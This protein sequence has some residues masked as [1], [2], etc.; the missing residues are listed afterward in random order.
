MI[1]SSVLGLN[2]GPLE[3][4]TDRQ[5][6]GLTSELQSL[7]PHSPLEMLQPTLKNSLR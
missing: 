1:Q 3:Y 5:P 6:R 7:L 2:A 4:R